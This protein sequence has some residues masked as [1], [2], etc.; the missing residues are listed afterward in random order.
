MLLSE[1]PP[2]YIHS[3]NN[4]G[5]PVGVSLQDDPWVFSPPGIYTLGVVLFCTEEPLGHCGDDGAL[6]LRL[7]HRRNCSLHL[8][9]SNHL[10]WGEPAAMLWGRS[11]SPVEGL[12]ANSQH[13]PASPV[14]LLG[15]W[16]CS[17]G[18][19]QTNKA[20]ND[21]QLQPHKRLWARTNWLSC[22]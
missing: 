18:H 17:L 6:L 3:S 22:T 13:S 11:S 14:G 20:L 5:H 15:S 2:V 9:L 19:L 4:S 21:I 8:V 7:D 12:L 16:S 10:L 1:C